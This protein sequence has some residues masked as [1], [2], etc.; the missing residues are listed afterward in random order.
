M[1]GSSASWI[2][3]YSALVD[4]SAFEP[5]ISTA[6]PPS[7]TGHLVRRKFF[8]GFASCG[9]TVLLKSYNAYYSKSISLKSDL[10]L[11]SRNLECLLSEVSLGTE[12]CR[13]H[14]W[15]LR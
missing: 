15:A 9:W 1:E 12:E 2:H 4:V 7:E 6:P 11:D 8:D 13:D 10:S 3:W 14:L 5:E